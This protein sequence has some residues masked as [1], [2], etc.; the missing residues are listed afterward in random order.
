MMKKSEDIIS[1][2]ELQNQFEIPEEWKWSTVG[3]CFSEIINGTTVQQNK[4]GNGVPVSR[5]ETIQN[6]KF[7]LNRIQHIQN[8]SPELICKYR[9]KIGDIA[10]SHIN[11]LEHV[12]KTA[13]YR[14]NPVTFLHGMNL[15]RL[16]ISRPDLFPEFAYYFMQTAFFRDEVRS[17]VGKAV[18]QVSINQKNLST[19]PFLLPPL[20][21]QQRIVARIEALLAHVNEARGQ[22]QRM[23]VIMKQF[24][25]GV[26]AAAC[27]GRLT[28]GWRDQHS[29]EKPIQLPKTSSKNET[30]KFLENLHILNELDFPQLPDSWIWSKGQEIFPVIT[31]G[32]RGW[33]KYYSEV[34]ASFI[35]IGNLTRDSI[36]LNLKEIQK[37]NPPDTAERKRIRVQINDILISITAD[38]GS[39]GF[40]ST[41]IGEAY[42]NQHIALCRPI[43]QINANF[44]AL[45][46][47]NNEGGKKQL[48]ELQ[49][50]ATKIGL[51]LDDIRAVQIPLPPLSE[52]HEIVRRVDAL[53][54]RAD[55]IERE[56][57]AATK[58]AEALT[59]AILT[60]A[61]RGEL[62]Q[63]EAEAG[64]V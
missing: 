31:S 43:D 9:Y 8:P 64:K 11:S 45:Y 61:F 56:V 16:R 14:G 48:L 21:E 46:L 44:V 32:S 5:I 55:A 58:R 34:G 39:I 13:L 3:E 28:E 25:Q 29:E 27:S 60:R 52:Q 22:L 15:L 63:H 19:V 57:V 49:R 2:N 42:I 36:L 62:V 37:V 47:L 50:G 59:Q 41:D 51:G 40:I 4:E 35:R 24:R 12:G 53:F 1:D 30:E 7:D 38:L 20:P 33:A 26:L 54:A 6:A 10:L 23:P 17:R 18:N